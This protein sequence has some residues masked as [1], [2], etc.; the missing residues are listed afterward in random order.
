MLY[1]SFY[2]NDPEIGVIEYDNI[3]KIIFENTELSRVQIYYSPGR[4]KVDLLFPSDYERERFKWSITHRSIST[5]FNEEESS[6]QLINRE[7]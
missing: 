5:G 7:G 4:G 6:K 1:S 2:S 3:D